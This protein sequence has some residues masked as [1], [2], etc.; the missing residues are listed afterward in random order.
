MPL[1]P[2]AGPGPAGFTRPRWVAFGA[3]ALLFAAT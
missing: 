1:R 3:Y 2:R